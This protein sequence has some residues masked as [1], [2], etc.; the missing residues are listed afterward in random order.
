MSSVERR[1]EVEDDARLNRGF[2]T[3]FEQVRDTKN[4]EKGDR[5][6]TLGYDDEWY[7]LVNKGEEDQGFRVQAVPLAHIELHEPLD[8]DHAGEWAQSPV[9]R[10][11]LAPYF[12][13]IEAPD[14]RTE[15]G[16]E[17]VDLTEP[18]ADAG[19]DA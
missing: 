10:T 3:V 18:E 17:R 14:F 9:G 8:A 2:V 7:K 19:S 4:H 13:D 16:K 12:D 15:N 5:F 11:L 6:I 1:S